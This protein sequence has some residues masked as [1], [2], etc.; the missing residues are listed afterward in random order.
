VTKSNKNVKNHA[1]DS[2]HFL[3]FIG[4]VYTVIGPGHDLGAAKYTLENAEGEP[5]MLSNTGR[6]CILTIRNL[7]VF[8]PGSSSLL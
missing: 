5:G 4:L 8:L 2:T 1:T 6:Q 3:E 7:Y